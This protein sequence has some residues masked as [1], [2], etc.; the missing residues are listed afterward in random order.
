MLENEVSQLKELRDSDNSYKWA[1]ITL[2]NTN[3]CLRRTINKLT[4]SKDANS[5]SSVETMQELIDLK[6]EYMDVINTLIELDSSRSG[7]Y[8]A[9]LAKEKE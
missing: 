7:Y 3:A 1:H 9:L 5:P 4:S 6:A 2:A 8:K